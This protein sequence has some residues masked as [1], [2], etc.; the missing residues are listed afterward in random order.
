MLCQIFVSP[1]LK[2]CVIITY[3]HGINELSH[4]LPND[5]RIRILGNLGYL[6]KLSE[7]Y[8]M[9]VECRVFF[10]DKS[11]CNTRRKLLK[12]RN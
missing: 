4:E 3:K 9:T 1:Q 11:F 8:E 2:R 10:P 12:N 5:L 6:R 7:I